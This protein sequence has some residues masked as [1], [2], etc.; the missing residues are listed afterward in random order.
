[1]TDEE[2]EEYERQE[3]L[4]KERVRQEAAT[5]MSPLA[6]RRCVTEQVVRY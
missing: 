5:L 6:Y 3:E 2:Y 4:A 1:M